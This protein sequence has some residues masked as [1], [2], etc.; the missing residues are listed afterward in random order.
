MM[1]SNV[2]LLLP[3]QWA[4]LYKKISVNIGLQIQSCKHNFIQASWVEIFYEHFVFLRGQLHF[5]GYPTDIGDGSIYG[6]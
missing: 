2:L 6:N 3:S 5:Q 1:I 4:W